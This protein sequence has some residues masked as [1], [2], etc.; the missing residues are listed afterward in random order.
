MSDLD[1]GQAER[2]LARNRQPAEVRFRR[3]LFL[4]DEQIMRQTFTFA[5]V[6]FAE[7]S[8]DKSKQGLSRPDPSGFARSPS[9]S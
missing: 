2:R 4:S 7:I 3:N 1:V 8:R 9:A 5:G 6:L